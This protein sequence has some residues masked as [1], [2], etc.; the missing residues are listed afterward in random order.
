MIC[1]VSYRRATPGWR[2]KKLREGTHNDGTLRLCS[3][4]YWA[5]VRL[6]DSAKTPRMP[7]TVLAGLAFV[8]AAVSISVYHWAIISPKLHAV[9]QQV[10]GDLDAQEG[11]GVA[12]LRASQAQFAKRTEERLAELERIARR[13]VHRVGFLRYNSFSDV[14][15]DLSFTLAL[16]NNDGDGV[17]L[18][19]IYSREETRTFGKAVRKFVP[20]QGASKEEQAAITM[21]RTGSAG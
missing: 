12:K 17:V 14:G 20:Q 15:S 18:T 7:V 19:S 10:E 11:D 5:R 4:T 9:L 1:E 21:A 3:G 16:L 8:I 2:D 13:E 6:D